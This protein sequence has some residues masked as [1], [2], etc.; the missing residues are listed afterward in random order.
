VDE[1]D[2]DDGEPAERT[3]ELAWHVDSAGA[4]IDQ[5]EAGGAS[6]G[7]LSLGA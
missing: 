7:R 5:P 3:V 1:D 6:K 4:C 2:D